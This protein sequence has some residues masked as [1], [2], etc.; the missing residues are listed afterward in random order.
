MKYEEKLDVSEEKIMEE[1]AEE[2]LEEGGSTET[3]TED[4]VR[5]YTQEEFDAEMNK[6]VDTEVNKRLDEIIP[7]RVKRESEKIRREYEDKMSPY[8]EAERVLNA[9]LDTQNIEDATKKMADFYREK[10]I[11]IPAKREVSYSEEDMKVL[12]AHEAREVINL[13]MDV[14]SDEI[15]RLQAKGNMTAREQAVYADLKA[16]EQQEGARQELLSLG[17]ADTVVD[18]KEFK[19]F[20]AQF[21]PQTPVK[22]IYELYSK[23][24][25]TERVEKIGSM[26]GSGQKEKLFYTPADVDRLTEKDWENPKVMER[27]RASMT[28]GKGGW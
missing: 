20:A 22:K 9:G 5:T 3:E 15:E 21:N 17:I 2:E 25:G 23:S 6:R 27:V 11:E 14:V 19:E 28:S 12:A 18:S 1:V 8:R 16:Y 26:K 7:R 10:G 24:Q 4:P 13:G